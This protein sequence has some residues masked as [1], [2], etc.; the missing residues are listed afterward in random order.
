MFQIPCPHC[1]PRNVA[2]FRHAGERRR[3]PDPRTATPEQW[4]TYLYVNDNA[5]AWT[6]ETWYHQLG[7]RRYIAVE[8]H[9]VTN[10]TRPAP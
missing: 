2:E 8:R 7:C 9:T 3:R 6:S 1:G 10:E 4:R 5:A